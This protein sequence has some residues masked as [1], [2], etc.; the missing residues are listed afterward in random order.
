MTMRTMTTTMTMRTM[1]IQRLRLRGLKTLVLGVAAGG[2]LVLAGVAAAQD[3]AQ[4]NSKMVHVKLDNSRVRVLDSLLEPGDKEQL[5]SH[6][7]YVT[8]VIAGGKVRNHTADGK[9]TE[10]ELKTGDVIYREALT[11]WAEN[12]GTTPIHLVIVELKSPG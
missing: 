1:K 3:P 6:P 11:H 4:V 12:I 2:L 10:T 7:A 5:H 8:Y 9:A